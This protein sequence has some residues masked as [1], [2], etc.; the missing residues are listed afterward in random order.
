MIAFNWCGVLLVQILKNSLNVFMCVS[1]QMYI[2]AVTHMCARAPA[3]TI[4][5][6]EVALH[7]KSTLNI[8]IHP[9]LPTL[10]LI[11]VHYEIITIMLVMLSSG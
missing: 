9:A 7:K 5:N 1:V 11:F 8:K 3:H 4:C 6:E 10:C 2:Y